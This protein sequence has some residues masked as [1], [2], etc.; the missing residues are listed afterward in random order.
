M[1]PDDNFAHRLHTHMCLTLD[2]FP[3]PADVAGDAM[4]VIE[5]AHPNCSGTAVGVA[6]CK[7]N[8]VTVTV[9]IPMQGIASPL[10]FWCI[11]EDASKALT[12]SVKLSCCAHALEAFT[13][14]AVAVPP[15]DYSDPVF[16]SLACAEEPKPI[17][18]LPPARAVHNDDK[19]VTFVLDVAKFVKSDEE[20]AAQGL[21]RCDYLNALGK[22]VMDC[23]V[24]GALECGLYLGELFELDE[25]GQIS[26]EAVV[27]FYDQLLPVLRKGEN[28]IIAVPPAKMDSHLYG[29]TFVYK[30][31]PKKLP[32]MGLVHDIDPSA[33]CAAEEVEGDYFV[34]SN[35]PLELTVKSDTAADVS[36]KLYDGEAFLRSLEVLQENDWYSDSVRSYPSRE[37]QTMGKLKLQEAITGFAPNALPAVLHAVN[38]NGRVLP[39]TTIEALLTV[40]DSPTAMNARKRARA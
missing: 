37:L 5:N 15:R 4:K 9:T 19:S 21:Q 29:F 28:L 11:G 20:I 16:R 34:Y 26:G 38:V 40:G 33:N 32:L 18:E 3:T 12:S 8:S 7:D 2:F 10:V 13:D 22:S 23:F 30:H 6:L 36:I 35:V 14:P 39:N 1:V 31:M 25:H 17:I 27:K 24:Q